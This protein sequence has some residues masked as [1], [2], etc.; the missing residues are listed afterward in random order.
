VLAEVQRAGPQ[1]V[2]PRE[3][4]YMV[5][6]LAVEGGG[7]FTVAE[8]ARVT[9]EDRARQLAEWATDRSTDRSTTTSSSSSS[10]SSSGVHAAATASTGVHTMHPRG[11][12]ADG[13]SCMDERPRPHGS[14]ACPVLVHAPHPAPALAPAATSVL[15]SAPVT[16]RPLCD[17]AGGHTVPAPR[18]TEAP[19]VTLL[20]AQE[21]GMLERAA[22][23]QRQRGL[24]HAP[25]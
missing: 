8:R 16:A 12:G 20:D 1:V 13:P 18:V 25:A 7:H 5:A 14:A 10:S 3:D 23:E 22:N 4:A 2:R 24:T 17:R 15:A 11:S 19:T 9:A 21:A 6:A